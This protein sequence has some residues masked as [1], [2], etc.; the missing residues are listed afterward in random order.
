MLCVLVG[1]HYK[2]FI[3]KSKISQ[4]FNLSMLNSLSSGDVKSCC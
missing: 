4:Q 2:Y 1:L 3:E